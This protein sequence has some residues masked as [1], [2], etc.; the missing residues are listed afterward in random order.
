[1]KSWEIIPDEAIRVIKR[2]EGFSDVTYLC[3]AG[4]KTCGHGL[5]TP[6]SDRECIRFEL[7]PEPNRNHPIPYADSVRIMTTRLYGMWRA[8]KVHVGGYIDRL[9]DPAKVA[10]A[11]MLYQLGPTGLSKFVRMW[12]AIKIGDYR[13]AANEMMRSK[14]AREDTPQ[15]AER[16]AQIMLDASV[17]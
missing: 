13:E 2:E 15:R 1:M 6:L 4:Y 9:P 8:L 17:V 5:R 7:I 10:I 3:S 11:S 12:A 14:W 16:M